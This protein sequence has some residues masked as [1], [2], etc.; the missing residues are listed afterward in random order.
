MGRFTLRRI[1]MIRKIYCDLDGVLADFEKRFIEISGKRPENVPSQEMWEI[2]LKGDAER[3]FF[4]TLD[5]THDAMHLWLYLMGLR[6]YK[7][8]ELEILTASGRYPEGIEFAQQKHRWM[9]KVEYGVKVN[10]VQRG[11]D[12]YQF[13]GEGILLIDDMEKN[14]GPFVQA[15]GQ[16]I[17]HKSALSTVEQLKKIFGDPRDE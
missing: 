10:T 2:I 3:P 14:L 13:A 15:G 6:E 16:V 1:K 12:K 9:A 11:V 4:E 7:G 5:L 17:H 8:I